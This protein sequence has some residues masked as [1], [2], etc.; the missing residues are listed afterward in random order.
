MIP[1]VLNN[2]NNAIIA[3]AGAD[4]AFDM[5]RATRWPSMSVETGLDTVPF[6]VEDYSSNGVSSNAGGC[7][8]R[9]KPGVGISWPAAW[10]ALQSRCEAAVAT[11]MRLCCCV[12]DGVHA[13]SHCA[14]T[15]ADCEHG[16]DENTGRGLIWVRL[17]SLYFLT[18]PRVP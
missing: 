12:P 3:T 18:Y 1:L 14:T 15:A 16:I 11:H 17:S 9:N 4:A 10:N 8:L 5:T 6:C 2:A 13:Q 7:L